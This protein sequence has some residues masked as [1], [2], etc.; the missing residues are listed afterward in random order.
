MTRTEKDLLLVVIGG[1]LLV[2]IVGFFSWQAY[3]LEVCRQV[4]N[5]Y[6]CR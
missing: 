2:A 5:H 4:P 6:S 1:A 3:S